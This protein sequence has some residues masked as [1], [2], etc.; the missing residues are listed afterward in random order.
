MM[1]DITL[2]TCWTINVLWSNKFQY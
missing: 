1:S 2:E